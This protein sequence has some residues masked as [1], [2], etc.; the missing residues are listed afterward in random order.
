LTHTELSALLR[1]VVSYA[2]GNMH[3][4]IREKDVHDA[5]RALKLYHSAELAGALKQ[6]YDIPGFKHRDDLVPYHGTE[7]HGVIQ[8]G[9]GYPDTGP[10]YFSLNETSGVSKNTPS[11]LR[12][13]AP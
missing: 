9:Y 7:I 10:L 8:S 6:L 4:R 12:H 2:R 5:V 13:N 1:Q 11:P 3:Y